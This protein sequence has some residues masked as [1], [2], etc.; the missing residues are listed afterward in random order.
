MTAPEAREFIGKFGYIEANGDNYY[1]A[2]HG[3]ITEVDRTGVW[4]VDN[5]EMPHYFK[6]KNVYSFVQREFKQENDIP[7]DD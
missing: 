4:F 5:E 7:N 2:I 3:R 1:K 6:L